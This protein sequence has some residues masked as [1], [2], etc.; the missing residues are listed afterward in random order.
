MSLPYR[1]AQV[2]ERCAFLPKLPPGA[3]EGESPAGIP[4]P[5]L[6][7][8]PP[9]LPFAVTDVPPEIVSPVTLSWSVERDSVLAVFFFES[10]SLA[11]VSEAAVVIWVDVPESALELVSDEVQPVQAMAAA[12]A[13]LMA[14]A[15][16]LCCIVCTLPFVFTAPCCD[17]F[18]V[19]VFPLS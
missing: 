14:Q 18:M 12:I 17:G 19:V 4:P 15:K 3:P 1:R 16:H 9:L 10:V 13:M 8:M 7:D 5:N 2:Q 11:L 6:P